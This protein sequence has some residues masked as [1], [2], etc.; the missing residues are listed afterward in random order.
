MAVSRASVVGSPRVRSRAIR[1]ADANRTWI[2]DAECWGYVLPIGS[3]QGLSTGRPGA[4][5]AKGD[6][7]LRAGSR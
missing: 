7:L 3:G 1:L 5:D 6:I 2:D 4:L